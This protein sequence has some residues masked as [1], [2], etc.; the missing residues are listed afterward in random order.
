MHE[1]RYRKPLPTPEECETQ[2]SMAKCRGVM[3][4]MDVTRM[5]QL[6]MAVLAAG[7]KNEI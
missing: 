2:E 4:V 7:C 1:A 3:N 5:A 6:V